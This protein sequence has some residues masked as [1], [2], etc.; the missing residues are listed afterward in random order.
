MHTACTFDMYAF[1][2]RTSTFIKRARTCTQFDQA[3]NVRKEEEKSGAEGK[4]SEKTRTTEDQKKKARLK[5]KLLQSGSCESDN[6]ISVHSQLE[7]IYFKS[8]LHTQDTVH[9]ALHIY[10]T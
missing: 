4:R 5:M 2:I 6:H 10:N 3:E 9:S 8:F 1:G 7:Q